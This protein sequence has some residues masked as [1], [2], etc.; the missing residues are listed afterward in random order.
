MPTVQG[1]PMGPHPALSL[2]SPC[3][4]WKDSRLKVVTEAIRAGTPIAHALHKL[5]LLT[6]LCPRLPV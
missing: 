5:L 3:A 6:L 2:R 4:L 1:V